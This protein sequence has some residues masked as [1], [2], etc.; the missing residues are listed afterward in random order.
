M[1]GHL[2]YLKTGFLRARKVFCTST[3][4]VYS[5]RQSEKPIRL[6]K[7]GRVFR[8]PVMALRQKRRVFGKRHKIDGRRRD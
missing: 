1:A 7:S 5:R 2:L 3:G 6:E 4:V 8:L